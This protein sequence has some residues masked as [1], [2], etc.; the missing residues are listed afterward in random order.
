MRLSSR[1]RYAVR[2]L[3]EIGKTPDKLTSLQEVE[4]KQTISAKYAKQILQPL[5]KVNII[6]SKRGVGGGYYLKQNP[7]NIRLEDIM[8]ALGN[9]V[10]IAPCFATNGICERKNYCGAE[11]TWNELQNLIEIFFKET[12][13]QDIIDRETE[14]QPDCEV[15]HE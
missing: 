8:N 9:E 10:K 12:T 14:A 11:K 2:T 13:L 3:V 1:I 7:K 4:K 15:N 5:E 6:G